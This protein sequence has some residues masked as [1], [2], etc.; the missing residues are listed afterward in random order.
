VGRLVTRAIIALELGI[1]GSMWGLCKCDGFDQQGDKI[2]VCA[3]EVDTVYIYGDVAGFWRS[4]LARIDSDACY[5]HEIDVW[6]G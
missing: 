5:P 4:N 6:T 1:P 2:T 3:H